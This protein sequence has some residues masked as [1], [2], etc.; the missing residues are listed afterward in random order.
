M[1]AASFGT[2]TAEV[3]VRGSTR[4]SSTVRYSATALSCTYMYGTVLDLVHEARVFG[5][6]VLAG[7]TCLLLQGSIEKKTSEFASLHSSSRARPSA[8]HVRGS[9][10]GVRPETRVQGLSEE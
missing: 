4:S 6:L 2:G 8:S 7:A 5:S 9:R 10:S 3:P 1:V